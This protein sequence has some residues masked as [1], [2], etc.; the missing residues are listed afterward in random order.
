MAVNHAA[1]SVF[2]PGGLAKPLTY[3]A[4]QD[5]GALAEDARLDQG[6]GTWE[7][8]GVTFKDDVTNEL[9]IAEAMER[10]VN[11]AAGKTACL[12]GPE[13]LHAALRRFGFGAKTCAVGVPGES[14]GLVSSK[15]ERWRIDKT[16]AARVGMG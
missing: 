16:T 10:H 1:Q 13:K 15:S 7:Y 9:S 6:G 11:I 14:S 8:N 5:V 12:I 2:E 3:A 4:A